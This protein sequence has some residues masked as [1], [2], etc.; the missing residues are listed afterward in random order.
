MAEE[1]L[2]GNASKYGGAVVA[3]LRSSMVIFLLVLLLNWLPLGLFKES[4]QQ[5]IVSQAILELISINDRN[6]ANN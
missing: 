6:H 2:T 1:I 4:L 5:S 3:L